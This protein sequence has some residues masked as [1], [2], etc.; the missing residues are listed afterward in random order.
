AL[1]ALQHAKLDVTDIANNPKY[2]VIGGTGGTSTASIIDMLH[3]LKEKGVSEVSPDL[4]PRYL[5]STISSNLSRAFNLKGVSQSVASACATSA[6]AIGYAYH[7]I[8][9]GKQDLMLAG[10]GE[11]DHW[12][13]TAIFDAMGALCSKYNDAPETA[14]R[15]YS[16][17]NDG[18]VI[19]GG[20]GM[21]VLES[22]SHAQ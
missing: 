5:T 17:D 12:S 21:V 11:E 18:F 8:A 20:G 9:A 19:A 14:S 4:A 22:L 7:L 13:Q 10:G 16:K 1:D 3:T 2:G 15:P 6:D